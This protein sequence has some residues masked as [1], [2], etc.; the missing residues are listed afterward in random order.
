MFKS[1]GATGLAALGHGKKFFGKLIE[2]YKTNMGQQNCVVPM[3]F[4]RS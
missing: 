4:L 1:V 3:E 2:I